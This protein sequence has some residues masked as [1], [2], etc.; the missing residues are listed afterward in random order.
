MFARAIDIFEQRSRG[1]GTQNIADAGAAGVLARIRDK[2]ARAENLLDGTEPSRAVDTALDLANY[3]IILAALCAG[4]WPQEQTACLVKGGDGICY[5]QHPGDV[6]YDLRSENDIWLAEQRVTYVSTG[7]RLQM[8]AGIWCRI[9]GRS[10]LMRRHQLLVPDN[11]IDNGYRGLLDVPIFNAGR[12]FLVKQG[13][14]IAQLVFYRS[15][16]PELKKVDL[17]DSSQRGEG[18]FGSTGL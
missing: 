3:G 1:Y 12:Q 11:V 14:R 6:G 2:M 17:L 4:T 16:L 8:P 7:V 5:P 18:G 9:A 13:E 15:V 10:G